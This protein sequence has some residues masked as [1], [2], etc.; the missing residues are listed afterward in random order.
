[1]QAHPIAD[2]RFDVKHSAGGMMDVEFAVQ[3][4]VLSQAASHPA[5]ALNSGNIAL[6]RAA[7]NVSLLP[8][9]VGEKAADAYGKLRS[10][11][12]LARLDEQTPQMAPDALQNEKSAVMALWEAVFG[13][14]PRGSMP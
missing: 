14:M 7:E 3:Y 8:K 1:M 4:L 2:D 9:G 5:L 12:H 10:A 13:S 11:Q 6:L